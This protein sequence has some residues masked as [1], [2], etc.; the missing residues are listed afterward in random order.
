MNYFFYKT[1]IGEI[2]IVED[3]SAIVR[4]VFGSASIA[5]EPSES[6]LLAEAAG[7]I[8]L[9]LE[10][11]LKSFS[12]P[13]DPRG[14]P[15]MRVVWKALLAIPY[16]GTASYS[17]IAAAVGNPKA[18]RAVGMANNRNPIPLI[19]PCHRVIGKNGSLTGY[20]GGLEI[21]KR[22]LSIEA[23]VSSHVHLL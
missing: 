7:Q 16:G 12:L 1:V 6:P 4:I 9:Y 10:G 22:L 23:G 8:S 15:F 21:K 13:L 11:R 2:G 18:C 3:G 14:T 20:A 5:G 19:I 17:D